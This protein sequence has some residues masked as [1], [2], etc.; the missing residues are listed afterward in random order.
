MACNCTN[1]DCLVVRYNPCSEGAELPLTAG[2]TGNMTGIVEFNGNYTDFTIGVESGEKIVI[3][4][5]L[6]N[7]YYVHGLE[8]YDNTGT[9]LNDTCYSLEARAVVSASNSTPIPPSGKDVVFN[10]VVAEDG[11]TITDSRLNG[12]TVMLLSTQGQSYNADFFSKPINSST[13]TG[14]NLPFFAGQRVTITLQH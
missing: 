13:L 1:T 8:L 9:L 14:M 4:A 7:G 2:Y 11:N 12:E 10:V 6:L 5:N 3:P